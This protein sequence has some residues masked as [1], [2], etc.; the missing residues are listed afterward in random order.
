MFFRNFSPPELRRNCL[1]NRDA[2][3]AVLRERR[4]INRLLKKDAR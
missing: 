4:L 1:K 2:V 3:V